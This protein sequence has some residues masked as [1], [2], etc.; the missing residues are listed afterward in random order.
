MQLTGG[1]I[2]INGRDA[3]GKFAYRINHINHLVAGV[4]TG[5][6]RYNKLNIIRPAG[7]QES[8]H[9]ILYG[10]YRAAISKIPPPL[11]SLRGAAG[12]VVSVGYIGIR[13]NSLVLETYRYRHRIAHCNAWRGL[14]RPII[15]V[16]IV[17]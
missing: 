16:V 14:N 3:S 11:C 10:Y 13:K 2:R 1:R 15:K 8:M 6:I 4:V 5:S 17:P 7:A 9:R 12:K